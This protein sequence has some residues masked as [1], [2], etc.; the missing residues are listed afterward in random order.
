MDRLGTVA[1]VPT[2]ITGLQ[3]EGWSVFSASKSALLSA[4]SLEY[5]GRAAIHVD[6]ASV[7]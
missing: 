7:G 1:G 5:V 3:L 6:A 4:S 2:F